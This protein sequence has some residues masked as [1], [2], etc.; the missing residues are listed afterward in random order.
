MSIGKHN[1][2]STF[3]DGFT[4]R[5]AA[6]RVGRKGCG[7]GPD[8]EAH[9][10][11]FYCLPS[12]ELVK[13]G[14]T[15]QPS[16]RLKQYRKSWRLRDQSVAYHETWPIGRFTRHQATRLEQSLHAALRRQF[17]VHRRS[18]WYRAPLD[19]I[20]AIIAEYV[21]HVAGDPPPLVGLA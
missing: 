12:N 18:E 11:W 3:R 6:R 13:V 16:F 5:E 4:N 1:V 15:R 9:Q 14:V 7:P 10:Y 17:E 2:Y 8:R 20:T 19:V 21:S